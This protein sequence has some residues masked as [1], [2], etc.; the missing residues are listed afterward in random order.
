MAF[1]ARIS[2]SVPLYFPHKLRDPWLLLRVWEDISS[3]GGMVGGLIGAFLFFSLR[4]READWRTKLRPG[5]VVACGFAPALAIGRMGCA[6]AH[7]HPGVGTRFPPAISLETEAARAY[8]QGVFNAAGRPFPPEAA[9]LASARAV[10]S[11][12]SYGCAPAGRH[13]PSQASARNRRRRHT[14][15]GVGLLEWIS[16]I[17]A[18]A[19]AARTG[20][21]L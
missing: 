11:G 7:D 19:P 13:A 3:F 4:C 17:R 21:A 2:C 8:L 12:I 9:A 16:V 20:A 5:D 14:R 1:S 10:G 6:L 15:H 18:A